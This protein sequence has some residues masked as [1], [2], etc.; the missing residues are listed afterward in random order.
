VRPH[1]P[2]EVVVVLTFEATWPTLRLVAFTAEDEQR[3]RVWLRE[4][5]SALM[6]TLYRE[7]LAA[8]DEE[9]AA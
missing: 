8:D 3:L 9:P 2:P 6:H 1:R 7:L 5:P 4:T